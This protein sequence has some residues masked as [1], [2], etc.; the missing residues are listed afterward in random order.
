M[1]WFHLRNAMFVLRVPCRA[2]WLCTS[3]RDGV[4]T[5]GRPD[6]RAN[7]Q[8]WHAVGAGCTVEEIRALPKGNRNAFKQGRYTAE[9]IASRREV[10]GAHSR[11]ARSGP[12]CRGGELRER[13]TGQCEAA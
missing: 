9:A 5:A 7:R 11:H 6:S 12:R 4:P 1:S 8:R 2:N 3:A 10:A 13:K